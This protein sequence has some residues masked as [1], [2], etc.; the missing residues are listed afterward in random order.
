MAL[1]Q[2]ALEELIKDTDFQKSLYIYESES[3]GL[4]PGYLECC[5]ASPGPGFGSQWVR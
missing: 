2:C 1:D 3:P 4:G 5:T